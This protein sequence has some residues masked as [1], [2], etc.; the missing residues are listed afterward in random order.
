VGGYIVQGSALQRVVTSSIKQINSDSSTGLQEL[1]DIIDQWGS[2]FDF[3]HTAAFTK[4][5]NLRKSQPAALRSVL[6]QLAGI[7]DTQLPL[8][9]PQALSNVLWACG[10]LQYPNSQLW[11]DTLTAVLDQL[12]LHKQEVLC[13]DVANTLHGL[14]NVASVNKQVVLGVPRDEVEAAV[15]QLMQHMRALV[16]H[17]H[18][19]GVKRAVGMRQAAY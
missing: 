4:A 3:I 5:A 13:V 18:L 6:D 19:E 8:A 9:G 12:Q 1:E 2:S 15:M 14:G 11:I 7:W 16:T 10:K 17:P